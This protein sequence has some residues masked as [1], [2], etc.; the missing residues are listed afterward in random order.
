MRR[1]DRRDVSGSL[2]IDMTGI[3][4]VILGPKS[5]EHYPRW[6]TSQVGFGVAF[7]ATSHSVAYD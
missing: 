3:E 5:I 7:V 2:T 6:R 4:L 1:T